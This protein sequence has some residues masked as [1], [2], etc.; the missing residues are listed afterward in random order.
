[1]KTAINDLAY[2]CFSKE[3]IEEYKRMRRDSETSSE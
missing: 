3:E 1:M 2:S